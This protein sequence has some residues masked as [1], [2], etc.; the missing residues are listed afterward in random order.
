[1]RGS[2]RISVFPDDSTD[3][4]SLMQHAEAALH[5][6]KINPLHEGVC[7]YSEDMETNSIARRVHYTQIKQAIVHHRV[8]TLY[9]PLVNALTGETIAVEALMRIADEAGNLI[10]PIEFITLAEETRLII[11][12]G[13]QMISQALAQLKVWQ[14]ENKRI[15][16]CLNISPIQFLDPH[17]VPFLLHTIDQHGVQ[18]SQIEREV[19]ESLMLQNLQ[20]VIR[21]MTQLRDIG[22]S[23]S[24]DDFGTGYSCLSYLK[25]LPVDVL[26][27]DRSFINQLTIETPE[28][29]LVQ[30]I[31]QLAKGASL[32]SVAEGVENE[33]QVH[34]LQEFG[35]SLLQGFYFSRPV[36]ADKIKTRYF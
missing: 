31:T 11:P 17:F 35:V 36:T 32:T 15:R 18:P 1:M 34:R 24:I 23:I 30:A 19:T 29:P 25:I 20:Q 27:I 9:Q 8:V 4:Q 5:R 14:S 22:I 3:A 7:F 2:L 6:A 33:F 21:D 13:E 10:S 28:E 26:K 12:L 16:L